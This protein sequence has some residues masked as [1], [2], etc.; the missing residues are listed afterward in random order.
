M[1][2]WVLRFAH[3]SLLLT[4]GVWACGDDPELFDRPLDDLS[5]AELDMLCDEVVDGL[6]SNELDLRT[7]CVLTSGFNDADSC[8]AAF[9]Y[10]LDGPA[11]VPSSVACTHAP[12]ESVTCELS[13][14]ELRC[15]RDREA[16]RRL[17]DEIRCEDI[18]GPNAVGLNNAIAIAVPPC[19]LPP[20]GC[21]VLQFGVTFDRP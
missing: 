17:L 19:P 9:A 10:C 2:R 14:A 13:Q 20:P 21:F 16:Q 4:P 3:W 18:A 8:A 6:R 15:M 1:K 7:L 11:P 5:E 12:A